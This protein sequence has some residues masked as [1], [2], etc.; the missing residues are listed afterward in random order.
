MHASRETDDSSGAPLPLAPWYLEHPRRAA[1]FVQRGIWQIERARLPRGKALLLKIARVILLSSFKFVEDKCMLRATALTLYLLLSLVPLLALAF[2]ISKGFGMDQL[3]DEKLQEL[4]LQKQVITHI[5]IFARNLLDKTSG[6]LMAGVGIAF[7]F[8]TVLRVLGN[9]EESFNAIWGV[10]KPRSFGRK[11]TD[12]F[13]II[14]LC[15]LLL[16]ISSSLTFAINKQVQFMA[17]QFEVLGMV[18]PYIIRALRFS[19]YLIIWILFSF[20]YLFIPNTR[21]RWMTGIIAGIVAGTIF[22]LGQFGYVTFQIGVA[23]YNAIYAGFAALPLF[24]IWLQMSWMIVLYGA[25]FAYAWQHEQQYEFLDETVHASAATRTRIALLIM[26]AI[27]ERFACGAPALTQIELQRAL[28]L[29]PRLLQEQLAAL[30]A[31][32]L[33]TDVRGANGAAS[34]YQPAR[35]TALLSMHAVL[36]ALEQHGA[37]AIPHAPTPGAAAI[38]VALA[39]LDATRAHAPANRLLRDL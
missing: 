27:I 34:T 3:L 38:A 20:L 21:V 39:E 25:E 33:V 37:E 29:P 16:L 31:C 5:T 17:D 35:D 6:G 11:C 19:T 2:A 24:I 9:I 22:Q 26:H 10:T 28:G 12:Y 7:L 14:I 13:S 23:R 30:V 32:D 36:S 4:Q 15:P 18:A 8:W 1:R